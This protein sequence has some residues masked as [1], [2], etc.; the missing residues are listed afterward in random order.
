MDDEL[1]PAQ[2]FNDD[3]ADLI[4]R[5]MSKPPDDMVTTFTMAGLMDLWSL[6]LKQG[7]LEDFFDDEGAD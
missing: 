5:W 4:Q 3:L 7:I 6:H 2:K 1:N